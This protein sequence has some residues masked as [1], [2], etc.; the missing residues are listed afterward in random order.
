MDGVLDNPIWETQALKIENFVQL[1]PKENG[2]PTEK[3][4]AYLGYDEKNL[5]LAFRAFDSQSSKVRCSITKRDSCM[6]DDW[7]FI[8]L[9]TF[10]EKRRAFSFLINPAGVQ[11]DMMRVEEGGNDNMDASWDTVFYSDGKIDAEGYTVEM[12]IPFKSLRFPND[13]LK[14][15]NLV[16]GRNLPR[17]G[18][19]ILYGSFSRDIPGL[20][21]QGKPFVIEGAVERSRNVEVMPFLTSLKSEGEK[22]QFEP[23]ANLKLGLS[24]NA[25]LDATINPDFS[26]IEADEPK[27]DYNVRYALRYDEKRPFF[28]E[29]MEIFSSPEIETV[30]TRQINDPIFGAKASGKTGRF[31]YGVLSAYDMHPTESLWDISEGS[32]ITSETKAFSNIFRTKADVG[33]GSYVGFTLTDKEL[34]AGNWNRLGGFD[35]QLRFKDR[36][37]FSF[38]ALASDTSTEGDRTSLSPGLYG[39]LYYTDKHWTFGGFYK[40][41][42]PEFQASLGFVNRVDYRSAGGFASYRLYPDKKY[43]NQVQFR[44]QGGQRMGYADSVTQDTWIRP[45]VQFRLT[46]F[47]QVNIGYEAA[48]ERFAGVDFKKQS[49]SIESQV[50]FISW[51]PFFFFFQTGD[52]INYD[53]ED[54]FLGYSNTYGV[55]L[56][57]KP[58]K[59]LQLGTDFSKQTFWRSAGGEQLWDYNLVREKV[60]YQFSKTLSVRAIVDYNFF[61][62]EAF[63]S[64]LASWVLRPGTLFFLGVDNDYLRDEYGRLTGNG[65][66][67]FVKFSYWWRL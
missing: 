25:T 37:F 26:Q 40:A 13:D 9:D 41:M 57:F 55:S 64:L 52:E 38:Q 48:M 1:S 39:E 34:G 54:A 12:A 7:V 42:D 62:K 23:G 33:S 2:V 27:I 31:T 58:S 32:S 63:G 36:V 18:E 29:G 20:L 19:V 24:S 66:N 15:W 51:M 59:R 43:L 28:L 11:M 60:T 67:V 21:T 5:Y 4:V 45:Q 6:E 30:Y 56:T 17:T 16:L 10:N 44:I 47:N 22:V 35:G 53:D 8:M 65:Y 46:E 14:T 49:L 3:T 61:D 50:T